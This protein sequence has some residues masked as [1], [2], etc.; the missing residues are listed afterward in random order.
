MADMLVVGGQAFLVYPTTGEARLRS[1]VRAEAARLRPV[2]LTR[3][4][5]TVGDTTVHTG[6]RLF[7]Q[8]LR[9]EFGMDDGVEQPKR[10]LVEAQ[11]EVDGPEETTFALHDV[12][13]PSGA[14][15][16]TAAI[17]QWIAALPECHY[18]IRTPGMDGAQPEELCV[19]ER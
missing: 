12:P 15:T 7:V 9:G 10:P 6:Q 1:A 2:R 18:S 3:M 19:Y 4:V 17:E 13:G 5:H 11:A 14:S 16:Y 8:L